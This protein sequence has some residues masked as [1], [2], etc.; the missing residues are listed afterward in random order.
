[1]EKTG[2]WNF[3]NSTCSC[4]DILKSVEL[5]DEHATLQAAISQDCQ[6]GLLCSRRASQTSQF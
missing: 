1:M 4:R 3:I 6:T 5:H 2:R